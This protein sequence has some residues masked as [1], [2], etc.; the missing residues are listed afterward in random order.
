MNTFCESI[1]CIC[2][3]MI[4]HTAHPIT[5]PQK[6]YPRLE[7]E[8]SERYSIALGGSSESDVSNQKQSKKQNPKRVKL[9]GLFCGETGT[10]TL[11]TVTRRQISNLLHY[12]SGTSPRFLITEVQM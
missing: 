1:F 9:L 3:S 11:A 7:D 6:T 10:R 12:H 8:R 5:Q 4:V 2:S